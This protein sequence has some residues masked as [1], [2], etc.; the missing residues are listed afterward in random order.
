MPADRM[1]HGSGT[2]M[3]GGKMKAK[4]GKVKIKK[5]DK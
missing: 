2:G 3:E 5:A 4:N 1:S